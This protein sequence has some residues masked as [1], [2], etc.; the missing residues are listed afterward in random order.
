MSQPPGFEDLLHPQLVCKLHNTLYGLKQAPR[1][2]NDQFTQFLPSLGFTTT[3]SD[4]SLFVKHVGPHIVVL[5]LY[6]NDII[7]TAVHLLQFCRLSKLSQPSL[8]S[9]T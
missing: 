3:Y 5:L 9:Q 6:V 7:I 1:A 4:P 2:W 8:T